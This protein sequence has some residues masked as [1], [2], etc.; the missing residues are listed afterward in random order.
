MRYEPCCKTHILRAP[1]PVLLFKLQFVDL[2]TFTNVGG[3]AHDA[4]LK[5]EINRMILPHRGAK[6]FR[7]VEGAGP[8]KNIYAE[9]II[10]TGRGAQR[11]DDDR[12]ST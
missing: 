9:R 6:S 3:G 2:I 4:P 8:Y 11:M 1:R 10:A 7:A 5:T 12:R